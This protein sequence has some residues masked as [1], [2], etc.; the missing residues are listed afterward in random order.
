MARHLEPGHSRHLDVEEQH[1]RSARGYPLDRLEPVPGL[2]CD[3]RRQLARYVGEELLQALAR[4]LLVVRDEDLQRAHAGAR[5]AV[6]AS[7]L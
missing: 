7:V 4:R 3:L 5:A 2:A 1:L 6:R